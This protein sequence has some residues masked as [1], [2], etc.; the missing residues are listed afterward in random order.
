[1]FILHYLWFFLP[2]GIANMM[3]V[4]VKKYFKFL[5]IPVDQGLTFR[6][7]SLL[8]KN[9]TVRGV[10]FGILGGIVTVFIQTYLYNNFEN[11]RSIS[12]VPYNEHNFILLGFLIGFGALLGDIVESF[13]KRQV[14]VA[15]G[16]RFFPFDQVDFVVGFLALT[17]IIFRPEWQ[18]YV[19]L[20]LFVPVLHIVTNHIGYYIGLQKTKW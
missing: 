7:K 15:P 13:F 4:F 17:S 2:A 16:D 6:G 14:S 8:G 19:F 12:I 10:V 1:M 5:N 20:I 9:K 3:P 18:V 11:F